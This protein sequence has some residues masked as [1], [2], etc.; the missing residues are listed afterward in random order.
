MLSIAGMH[1]E[2]GILTRD[3]VPH[4]AFESTVVDERHS[5]VLE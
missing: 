5:R 1:M 3:L 4:G 2:P